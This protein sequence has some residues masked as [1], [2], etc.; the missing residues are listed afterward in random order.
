MHTV[1]E[2]RTS[3]TSTGWFVAS[4]PSTPTAAH[5]SSLTVPDTV[6]ALPTVTD[7]LHRQT[8]T[9]CQH[10]VLMLLMQ[11]SAPARAVAEPLAWR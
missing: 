8:H 4:Y 1:T 2:H 3:T 5:V 10:T 7:K 9:L 11:Q 6:H